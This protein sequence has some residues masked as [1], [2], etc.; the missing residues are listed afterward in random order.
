MGIDSHG[1][2][3]PCLHD[4]KFPRKLFIS[5]SWTNLGHH[6]YTICTDPFIS[7]SC[8]VKDHRTSGSEDFNRLLPYKYMTE[9]FAM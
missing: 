6:L 7:N 3:L 2:N 9:I 8:Q 4:L 5:R 1:N